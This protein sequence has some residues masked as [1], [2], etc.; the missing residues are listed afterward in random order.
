MEYHVLQ[1]RFVLLLS[2][3]VVPTAVQSHCAEFPFS[4]KKH[5][6]AYSRDHPPM[7]VCGNIPAQTLE[8]TM[9]VELVS[10]VAGLEKCKMPNLTVHMDK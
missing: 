4:D 2:L 8:D 3:L 5:G 7:D 10:L 1:Q 9:H 6:L